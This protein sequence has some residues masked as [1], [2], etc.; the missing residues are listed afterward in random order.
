MDNSLET[1]F[2]IQIDMN[3]CANDG[4]YTVMWVNT[5]EAL[6]QLARK[7][8]VDVQNQGAL[9]DEKKFQGALSHFWTMLGTGTARCFNWNGVFYP[10]CRPLR[11]PAQVWPLCVPRPLSLTA[12][13][14]DHLRRS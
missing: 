11:L 4:R 12:H 5:T 7:L 13:Q 8:E 2:S 1:K 9:I 14:I 6:I 10:P 3:I